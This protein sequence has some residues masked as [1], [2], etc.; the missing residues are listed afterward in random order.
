[1]P[2][3]LV[4]NSSGFF[5]LVIL[6]TPGFS[7]GSLEKH[8]SPLYWYSYLME[9]HLHAYLQVFEEND[10]GNFNSSK[11]S[12]LIKFMVSVSSVKISISLF[13]LGLWPLFF[14][15]FLLSSLIFVKVLLRLVL[16]SRSLCPSLQ[17]GRI[18]VV[19]YHSRATFF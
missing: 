5:I 1:M 4:S 8:L 9:Y 18:A 11:V 12:Y 2:T 10:L 19:C 16:N 7:S 13:F 15:P 3:L 17:T 14:P 6:S